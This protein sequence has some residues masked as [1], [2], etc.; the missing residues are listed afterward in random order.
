VDGGLKTQDEWR[1]A[2]DQTHQEEQRQQRLETLRAQLVAETSPV[3]GEPPLDQQQLRLEQAEKKLRQRKQRASGQMSSL[4]MGGQ[5]FAIHQHEGQRRQSVGN[6]RDLF[7][8]SSSDPSED[9][10]LKSS[11]A[12]KAFSS[13]IAHL[14]T[15]SPISAQVA[16]LPAVTSINGRRASFS[17]HR[18]IYASERNP[19]TMDSANADY[20][21]DGGAMSSR[22]R[23][24]ELS[25]GAGR[26]VVNGAGV[27]D[28]D[29][30]FF[31]AQKRTSGMSAQRRQVSLTFDP[32]APID[33]LQAVKGGTAGARA[34]DMSSDIFSGDSSTAV[35]FGARRTPIARPDTANL[36]HDGRGK[37]EMKTSAIIALH[38][39][40]KSPVKR[41][42][43]A[44][45]ITA[46]STNTA[47]RIF[48]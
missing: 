44:G 48:G 37:R 29:F 26:N 47:D 24:S 16:A 19:I 45:I 6:H 8:I 14:H 9:H 27:Q 43:P 42:G 25:D 39:P 17:R 32:K 5:D 21:W 33:H 11:P 13:S 12:R 38:A 1:A 35:S 4:Q 34:V 23:G 31:G 22:R 41:S 3:K 18:L 7:T 2:A 20:S 15:E 46:Q 36:L 30:E 10:S 40:A 28:S